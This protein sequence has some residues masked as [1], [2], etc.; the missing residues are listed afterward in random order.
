MK[1][2]GVV[3]AKVHAVLGVKNN[4]CFVKIVPYTTENNVQ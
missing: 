3:N 1:S 2:K 4:T